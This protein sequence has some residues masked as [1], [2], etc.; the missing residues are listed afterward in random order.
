[1]GIS[2]C[3][4]TGQFYC[5]FCAKYV[6]NSDLDISKITRF[7]IQP[8][9]PPPIHKDGL[10]STSATTTST[11]TNYNQHNTHKPRVRSLLEQFLLQ[12]LTTFKSFIY[13]DW[14]LYC[15]SFLYYFPKFKDVLSNSTEHPLIRQ[16]PSLLNHLPSSNTTTTPATTTT[17]TSSTSTTTQSSTPFI[18]PSLLS[19]STAHSVP[20]CIELRRQ[21]DERL[22][23][24]PITNFSNSQSNLPQWL[25]YLTQLSADVIGNNLL[26]LDDGWVQNQQNQLGIQQC[27]GCSLTLVTLRLL[28]QLHSSFSTNNNAMKSIDVINQ[29]EQTISVALNS[30]HDF[31]STNPPLNTTTTESTTLPITFYIPYLLAAFEQHNV[32]SDSFQ[33]KSTYE[34]LLLLTQS[35]SISLSNQYQWLNAVTTTYIFKL[36]QRYIA[37]WKSMHN[38]LSSPLPLP[39]TSPHDSNPNFNNQLISNDLNPQNKNFSNNFFQKIANL[40]HSH[41][42]NINAIITSQTQE[43]GS[44]ESNPAQNVKYP[45][46]RVAST[47]ITS[48]RLIPENLIETALLPKH[49]PIALPPLPFPTPPQ[50]SS[51][52]TT[53]TTTTTTTITTLNDSTNTDTDI[54]DSVVDTVSDVSNNNVETDRKSILQYEATRQIFQLETY[55]RSLVPIWATAQQPALCD[56]ASLPNHEQSQLLPS[57]SHYCCHLHTPSSLLLL[58][59][60][61]ELVPCLECQQANQC[62]KFNDGIFLF[63]SP[64]QLLKFSF[65]KQQREQLLQEQQQ[66]QQRQLQ[67]Q[68]QQQLQEKQLQLQQQQQQQQQSQQTSSSSFASTHPVSKPPREPASTKR[69]V[70][71]NSLRA[72]ATSTD[73][74]ES[75]F[76]QQEQ[77]GI[78]PQTA[79]TAQPRKKNRRTPTA[80]V[81]DTN[82]SRNNQNQNS[83]SNITNKTTTDNT[84]IIGSNRDDDLN[85]IHH[86]SHQNQPLLGLSSQSNFFNSN[87]GLSPF[88]SSVYGP[89]ADPK[90]QKQYLH[91]LQQRI[92]EIQLAQCHRDHLYASNHHLTWEDYNNQEHK[93]MVSMMLSILSHPNNHALRHTHQQPQQNE[94]QIEHQR[95]NMI[96][97]NSTDSEIISQL[98]HNSQM[99]NTGL[100]ETFESLQPLVQLVSPMDQSQPNQ[101]SAIP[102]QTLSPNNST[103]R[104]RRNLQPQIELQQSPS[105]KLQLQSIQAPFSSITSLSSPSALNDD[106]FQVLPRSMYQ[107]SSQTPIPNDL[108][109]SDIDQTATTSQNPTIHNTKNTSNH[110]FSLKSFELSCLLPLQQSS[111]Q[112]V[113]HSHY[114]PTTTTKATIN[115]EITQLSFT[116][117]QHLSPLSTVSIHSLP[118]QSIKK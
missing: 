57:L 5:V 44:V 113:I 92:Q 47:Y 50:L 97:A 37:D 91:W 3:Q 35:L 80:V 93:S 101:P 48:N 26:L 24:R 118:I 72:T 6:F 78:Q 95:F 23:Q 68:L 19:L 10:L 43:R 60:S 96:Q 59:S 56:L 1:M 86:I 39:Q 82:K 55:N 67:Q 71:A 105:Q 17:T 42:T 94:Q 52:T 32:P 103:T 104:S 33:K 111:F 109:I 76:N 7:M 74:N 98:K 36:Q 15:P 89:N 62:A 87:N 81:T 13:F 31:N 16:H 28:N 114:D 2:L 108:N 18:S 12:T 58:K 4:S 41:Q 8:F 66:L 40:V 77:E 106:F 49:L 69:P 70:A 51:S 64:L 84:H 54:N 45:P 115:Q 63:P 116:S 25:P 117:L 79:S 38:L 22:E 14:E 102:P 20:L 112:H 61:H 75:L 9:Q 85:G 73:K 83:G 11:T 90:L 88:P 21:R 46:S 100:V 110:D 30:I 107:Y 99:F 27:I 29:V 34:L 53:T 65:S